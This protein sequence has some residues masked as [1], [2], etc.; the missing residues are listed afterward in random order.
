MHTYDS[1]RHNWRYD[2]GGYAWDNAELGTDLWLWF[3]AMRSGRSDIFWLA[4]HMTRHV[5]E[6][7]CF[8]SGEFAGLG[9]RHNV[10]H[11]GDGAKEARVSS[12]MNRR[13]MYYITGGDETLGELARYAL[14]T[15]QTIIKWE[16]LRNILPKPKAPTRVRIG[17]DWLALVGNW[18]FEFERT[19]DAHYKDLIETGMRDIGNFKYGLFTGYSSAVGFDPNTGHLYEEEETSPSFKESYHRQCQPCSFA[20]RAIC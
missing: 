18:L 11:W 16:A 1:I 8:H 10:S 7:D 14:Q 19:G 4:Y 9:S 20:T 15:D 5:S 13:P 3:A 12:A 6:S 17:P 2:V